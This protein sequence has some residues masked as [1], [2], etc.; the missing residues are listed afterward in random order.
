M[1]CDRPYRVSF[2]GTACIHVHDTSPLYTLKH[3][4]LLSSMMPMQLLL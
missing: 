3:K 1:T 4:S 2:E